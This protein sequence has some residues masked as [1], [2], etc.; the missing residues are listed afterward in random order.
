MTLKDLLR[1]AE[2]AGLSDA[3]A[4]ARAST[5]TRS[6]KVEMV[7]LRSLGGQWGLN[8]AAGFR[9]WLD[10]ASRDPDPALA[11]FAA[12]VFD[13]LKGP[14]F[15]ASHSDVTSA[16][17][18]LVA[19]GACTAEEAQAVLYETTYPAGAAVTEAE[20]AEARRQNLFADS[21]LAYREQLAANYNAAVA[22]ADTR[23]QAG[24]MPPGAA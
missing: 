14:G 6:P 5:P 18:R 22:D 3:D 17:D 4:A 23:E 9:G 7:T 8:R 15:D 1:Q 20:V 2:Y 11:A 13:L 10:V 21:W 24:E 12:T 16:V 19:M